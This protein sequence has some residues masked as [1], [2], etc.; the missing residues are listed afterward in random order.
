KQKTE[1]DLVCIV[2]ENV[3]ESAKASLKELFDY[4]VTIDE[5]YVPHKNRHERQDRPFLFTRFHALRLGKDGDLGFEYEK[6]IIADADLL[7]LRD[8]DRLFKIEAPAGV[9]NEKKDYCM[10]YHEGKYIIPDSVYVDGTWKWHRIYEDYPLGTK[11][12]KDITDRVKT[13][14]DNM[15][16]NAALYLFEP[17]MQLFNDIL[18]DVNQ[19]KTQ[20]EISEY[21]WPEMQYITAKMSGKWHNMDLKYS[22]FN[23]YPLIDVLRGIHFAGLKP[24]QMKHRS[25]KHFARNED[26]KLWYAVYVQMMKEYDCL[27]EY[28]KLRKLDHDINRLLEDD[29]F[30]FHQKYLPN[31]I[32]IFKS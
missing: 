6:I 13:D 12:P 32:H 9:I 5:L 8:Y 23:G 31:L 3:S 27:N 26:Y 20:K 16:V 15:G 4:V 24:W 11:I 2:T 22:S 14:K 25:I 10:E 7:P 29:R 30:V 28:P 21:P 18:N 1:A 17:S 19:E